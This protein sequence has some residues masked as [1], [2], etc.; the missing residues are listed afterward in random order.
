MG[1]K[2]ESQNHSPSLKVDFVALKEKIMIASQYVLLQVSLL[3]GLMIT[4]NDMLFLVQSRIYTDV[5]LFLI[6]K[7]ESN[8]ITMLISPG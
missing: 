5:K 8:I 7:V 4:V 2:D 1:F 6:Y 3:L